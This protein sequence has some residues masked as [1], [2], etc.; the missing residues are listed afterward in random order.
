LNDGMVDAAWQ[1]LSENVAR[2]R[3]DVTLDGILV[4]TLH[5]PGTE[6]IIGAR[7]DPE[8]GPIVMVG[9]G[10][11]WTEALKDVRIFPAGLSAVEIRDEIR[12]L[13]GAPIFA[14]LR[15]APPLDI[16]EPARIAAAIGERM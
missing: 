8:W 10:G 14:G 9:L 1:K 7:R 11:V 12:R 4:E 3:P 2:L 5:A 13:K 16:A 6:M 15:G